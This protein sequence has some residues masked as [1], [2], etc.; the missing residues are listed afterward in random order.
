MDWVLWLQC[1]GVI[2]AIGMVAVALFVVFV[3]LMENDHP[4]LALLYVVTVLALG[5]GSFMYIDIVKKRPV[6][7]VTQEEVK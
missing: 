3:F 2:L 7:A 1:V 5:I 6:E 4:F